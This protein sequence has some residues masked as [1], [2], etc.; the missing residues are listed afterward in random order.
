MNYPNGSGTLNQDFY[1][2]MPGNK[3]YF[4]FTTVPY[5]VRSLTV[6]VPN[7]AVPTK[8]LGPILITVDSPNTTVPC[9]QIDI[10]P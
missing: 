10:N 2:V 9:K 5:G 6:F 1:P 8:T 7:Q 4:T 3:G